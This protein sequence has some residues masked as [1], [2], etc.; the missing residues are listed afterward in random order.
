M[1]KFT[2][3]LRRLPARLAIG[4][5]AAAAVVAAA[6]GGYAFAASSAPRVLAQPAGTVYAC[7]TAKGA[8]TA[9]AKSVKCPTGDA[10]WHWS[11]AGPAG[12]RGATGAKGATGATGAK[13]ATG[14]TGSK[15]ATGPAGPAGSAGSVTPVTAT[16]TTAIT[17][18]ADSGAAGNWATDTLTRS[19]TVTRHGA[20]AVADCGGTAANGITTCWYYTASMTDAGSFITIA[21]AKSPQAGVTIS[22]TLAGTISGGSNFEF[23]SS[24]GAPSASSVPATLDASANGTDSSEWPERFFPSGTA[25]G[26]VNE[27]N[28][29]Y[30]YSAPTTC[31]QWTDAY[32]NSDGSLAADGDIEGVNACKG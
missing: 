10:L 18:D 3:R 26:G 24:S 27:I 9:E 11:V 15:G 6:G 16:A 30:T 17:D 13:G 32:D 25:F 2:R 29:V 14:A 5:A 19:M 1:F 4:I 21:G 8:L 12:A 28:W 31:E 20:A 22:G 23:Y 7:V